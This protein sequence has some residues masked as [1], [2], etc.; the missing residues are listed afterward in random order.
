MV[1]AKKKKNKGGGMLRDS[2][3]GEETWDGLGETR[4]ADRGRKERKEKNE[5]VGCLAV[6]SI[7]VLRSRVVP[8]SHTAVDARAHQNMHT[9]CRSSVFP[10]RF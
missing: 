10:T 1:R 4:V 8:R 9:L 5:K 6:C 7:L 2:G 3:L